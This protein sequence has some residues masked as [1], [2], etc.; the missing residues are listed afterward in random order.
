MPKNQ[1]ILPENRYELIFHELVDGKALLDTLGE[2]VSALQVK[3][4]ELEDLSDEEVISDEE[5]TDTL[6]ELGN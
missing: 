1:D 2:G 3:N 6:Q 5:D 4:E